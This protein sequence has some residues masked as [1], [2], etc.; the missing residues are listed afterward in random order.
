MKDIVKIIALVGPTASGKT[1][2]SIKLAQKLN[3]EV[4]SA[5][6]RLV[7]KDFNI[8]T[9]K[10]T[11]EEILDIPHHLIDVANPK[12]DFSV[13]IYKNEAEK[14]IADINK[15]N[16]IPIVTGGTG[17]Y[18]KALLG[19]LEIPKVD[20]DDEYRN[21]LEQLALEKGRDF[22]H[23]LL[24]ETDPK[25]AE[26]LHPND[27]FRVIRALEVIKKLGIPMSEAQKFSDSKYKTLYVGL[28]AQNREF[29]YDRINQRVDIMFE[30]GLVE[31][32]K[33]LINKYGKTVSLLKTLGYKEICEYLD[34][35][36]SYD[37]SIE[38]IKKNTRNFA[39]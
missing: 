32:V 7:Y 20:P 5:D 25:T 31:E 11:Q 35:N 22:L 15:R 4:I 27:K 24:R 2:V 14:I 19:N 12:D 13:G 36:L 26:K 10:P 34:G 39:K 17:F 9:A 21:E 37:D 33:T 8:G 18:V 38:L 28:N 30:T 3:G 1:S 6:S 23:N 16:K 29:L